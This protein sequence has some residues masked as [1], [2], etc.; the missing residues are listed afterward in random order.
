[1]LFLYHNND[2]LCTVYAISKRDCLL[3]VSASCR[4]GTLQK[5]NLQ[6]AGRIPEM[7]NRRWILPRYTFLVG[8]DS[9]CAL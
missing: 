9:F 6:F 7:K 5:R 8:A 1:M 2:K 3:Q 4:V